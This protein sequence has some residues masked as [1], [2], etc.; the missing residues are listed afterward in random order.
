M[1]ALPPG[2]S[3][4]DPVVICLGLSA[5]DHIWTLPGLPAGAGKTRATGFVST[6]GG[7]AATAS[8]AV[9]RLG[10]LARFWGRGGEDSAGHAMLRELAIEG[11]DCSQF[12]LF[13][14]AKSSVSG[15]LV[16]PVGERT[17]VNFRGDGL[18]ADP[19]WLPTHTVAEAGA[20]LA[21]PRWPEGA[22]HAFAA[23]R[24][25][26][27]T[28]VLDA[29]VAEADVFDTLLP[30]TDHAIFSDQALAAYAGSAGLDRIA[31][32]GCAVAAVTRGGDGM[33]WIEDGVAHHVPAFLVEVA[34]TTGAGDV[35]HGAWAFAIAAGAPTR[36]A[37][38]FAAA[39]AALKCTR[40]T[41]R[42]GIPSLSE[43]LN[44]WRRDT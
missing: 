4:R 36:D 33:H 11:V 18:P 8:V 2:W 34:D 15:V 28:T 20:V 13:K 10:G 16:D 21:D 5:Y 42:A 24:A 7:I 9:A 27:V 26:G 32:M 35:F 12:R 43:T 25:A 22:A 1:T 6:G 37:A 39:A 19:S 31:A 14:G 40:P 41:G 29:D 23:A 3:R 38:G 17:I 44:L 30:L